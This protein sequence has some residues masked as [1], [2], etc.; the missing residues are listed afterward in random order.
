MKPTNENQLSS[1]RADAFAT[2]SDR[3]SSLRKIDYSY[4]AADLSEL[5]SSCAGRGSV[6]RTPFRAISQDYFENEA[7]GEYA[8]EAGAFILIVLTVALPLVHAAIGLMD[9]VRAL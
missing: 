8:I 2:I 1:T 5:G 7:R 4:H 3:R 6:S 9:L